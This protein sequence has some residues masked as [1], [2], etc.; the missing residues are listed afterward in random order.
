MYKLNL[1]RFY[2]GMER[3]GY[4]IFTQTVILSELQ[5]KIF[6]TNQSIYYNHGGKP[7]QLK[8]EWFEK[9]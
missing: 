9:I 7:I 8:P 2:H 1:N 6:E 4:D 5:W 3:L